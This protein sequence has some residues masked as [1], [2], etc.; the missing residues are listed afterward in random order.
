M[1]AQQSAMSAGKHSGTPDISSVINAIGNVDFESELSSFLYRRYGAEHFAVL[2]FTPER[3]F[4]VVA[5]SLDGTDTA[6]RQI[7]LY[8]DRQYWRFDPNAIEAQRM[9]GKHA[10]SLMRLNIGNLPDRDMRDSLYGRTR[11]CERVLL[12]GGGDDYTIGLSVLRPEARG[13]FA[14]AEIDSL[15]QNC[16]TLLAILNKHVSLVSRR[17]ELTA[18]LTSVDEILS[19]IDL[20]PANL[21]R[22]EAEVCARL[23]GGVSALG[24]AL[25]LGI[26]EETVNTYR[27]RSYQRLGIASQRELLLWYLA[28][29][30]TG[31]HSER[32]RPEK[33]RLQ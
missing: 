11:I 19:Y 26:S 24:I 23:I 7:G 6:H 31:H 18:A 32:S 13:V 14:E 5:V 9:I 33:P 8:L 15:G 25:E 27:K 30:G 1:S 12:C 29:W 17:S 20:A 22:R 28:L 2:R 3:P 21:P 4:E 10:T 16:E